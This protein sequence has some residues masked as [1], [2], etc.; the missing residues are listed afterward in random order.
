MAGAGCLGGANEMLYSEA[1]EQVAQW[2][3]K[4]GVGAR[5]GFRGRHISRGLHSQ[6]SQR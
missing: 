3:G 6:T 1:Q 4:E 5:K 2:K